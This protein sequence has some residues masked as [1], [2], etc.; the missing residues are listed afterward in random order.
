MDQH[1]DTLLRQKLT[2]EC[3]RILYELRTPEER[4]RAEEA[5]QTQVKN[6]PSAQ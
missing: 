1:S 4:K 2:A 3:D 5:K 6:V